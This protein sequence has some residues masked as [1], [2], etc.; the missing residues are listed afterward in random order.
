MKI[1]GSQ[2]SCL[3]V[4]DPQERLMKAVKGPEGVV[5]R[6]SILIR[7][8]SLCNIPIIAT[9]QYRK[10]LGAI[11]PELDELLKNALSVDKLEFNAFFND[12]FREIVSSL[13]AKVDSMIITGVEAHICIFQ[14]AVS[15][16]AHGFNTWVVTDA[17]SSRNKKDMKAA[18]ALMNASGIHCATSEMVV[19]QWLKRAGTEQF[20]AMIEHLK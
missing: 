11:V 6:M 19:Y 18:I 1:L 13:P 2:T 4:I 3:V 15:A 14:T 7:C 9:T 12:D 16:I 5:D 10:G 20:K 17:I 8:A